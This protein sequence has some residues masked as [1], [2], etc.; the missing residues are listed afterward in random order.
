MEWL[1][2]VLD[3]ILE[4]NKGRI[5]TRYKETQRLQRGENVCDEL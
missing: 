1:S 2:I 3:E 4:I 5:S